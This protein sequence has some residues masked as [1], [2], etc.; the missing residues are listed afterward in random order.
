MRCF[1]VRQQWEELLT[2]SK[3]TFDSK[4]MNFRLLPYE[5]LAAIIRS[6]YAVF[7]IT[8]LYLL[9]HYPVPLAQPS[10]VSCIAG[11]GSGRQWRLLHAVCRLQLQNYGLSVKHPLHFLSKFLQNLSFF[12]FEPCIFF[13][14]IRTIVD[15]IGDFCVVRHVRKC[16][17]AFL[18]KQKPWKHL[19]QR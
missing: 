11:R 4:Q 7:G 8:T 1:Y 19:V 15:G 18:W 13:Q 3:W 16:K 14:D 12:I 9:H 10:C 2:A 6:R 5:L 17:N